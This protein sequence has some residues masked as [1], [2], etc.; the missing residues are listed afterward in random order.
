MQLPSCV[1]SAARARASSRPRCV[2]SN[3]ESVRVALSLDCVRAVRDASRSVSGLRCSTRRRA[4]L[5]R[6]TCLVACVRA[7]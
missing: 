5:A 3:S 7:C 1:L 6:T 4:R 2:H